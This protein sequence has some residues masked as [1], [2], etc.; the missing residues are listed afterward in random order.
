LNVQADENVGAP[1][2]FEWKL[3][4]F[5]HRMIVLADRVECAVTLERVGTLE[6][7]LKFWKNRLHD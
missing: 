5:R 7:Q 6:D 4:K 1:L 2:S 3:K